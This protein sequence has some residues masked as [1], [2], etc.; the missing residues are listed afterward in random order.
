MK[1]KWESKLYKKGDK[2]ICE[3]PHPAWDLKV[4]QIYIIENTKIF[5]WTEVLG[6]R[7]ALYFNFAPKSGYDSLYFKR[8]S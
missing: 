1:I 6:K 2:V 3:K 4:G 7:Q 8:I 5:T